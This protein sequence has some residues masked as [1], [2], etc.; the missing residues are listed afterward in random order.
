MRQVGIAL[1]LGLMACGGET[2]SQHDAQPMVDACVETEAELCARLAEEC[3]SLSG[4]DLCGMTRQVECGAC[5]APETCGANDQPNQCSV[6][7]IT[8][9]GASTVE[10]IDGTAT[11][12]LPVPA[13]VRE[14]DL[15]LALITTNGSADVTLAPPAGWTEVRKT[16]SGN[17]SQHFLHRRT[18]GAAEPASYV[19]DPTQSA[20][21]AGILVVYRGVSAVT[22]I[23]AKNAAGGSGTGADLTVP[24]PD[25]TAGADGKPGMLVGF[26]SV[27]F[28]GLI[29]TVPSLGAPPGMTMRAHAT[30]STDASPRFYALA[31]FDEPVPAAGTLTGRVS[32]VIVNCTNC[33]HAKIGNAVLLRR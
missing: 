3:G 5:V 12:T 18:A 31:A 1:L 27:Y 20:R 6:P 13:G 32:T 2:S 28:A 10:T 15:L 29:T 24:A 22:P 19:W 14:G 16:N 26:H 8:F 9:V 33:A 4:T 21:G 11:M 7:E 17:S 23:E 30:G 25:L